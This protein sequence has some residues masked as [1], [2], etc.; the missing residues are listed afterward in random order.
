VVYESPQELRARTWKIKELLRKYRQKYKKIA[1]V[2]HFELL[3]SLLAKSY[4]E[5]G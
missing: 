4:N 1:I 2:S 3:E 5:I